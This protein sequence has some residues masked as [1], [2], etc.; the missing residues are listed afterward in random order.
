MQADVMTGT[1]RS[2]RGGFAQFKLL[3]RLQPNVTPE[4]ARDA[5]QR[6]HDEIA[7]EKVRGSG[8]VANAR[9]EVTSAARGYSPQRDTFAKPIAILTGLVVAILLITCANVA[10]LSL[11]RATARR[12]EIAMPMAIGASR[13]RITRQLLT[14]SILLALGGSVAGIVLGIVG[15]RILAELVSSGPVSSVSLGSASLALDLHLDARVMT[16]AIMVSVL[17]V[18][19]FGLMPAFRGPRVSLQ[20]VLA[21]RADVAR[22]A[23]RHDA[24][25]SYCKSRCRSSCSP[26]RRSSCRRSAIFATKTLVPTELVS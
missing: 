20:S 15:M 9:V 26:A 10:G 12:R 24:P 17:A 6:V 13:R 2:R 23:S 19:L 7:A 1:N 25:W 16:F 22:M 21:R 14:E 18:L 5:I 11:A 3:G 8:V 4:H